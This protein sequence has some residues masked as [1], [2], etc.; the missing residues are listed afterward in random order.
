MTPPRIRVEPEDFV[1]EE[2]PVY[3]PSGSGPH[4]WCRVEKR[5]RTTDDVVDRLA[6]AAGV[7]RRTVGIA[8]R[9]DR[10]AVTRQ[11]LSVPDLD[12]EKAL[13]I[14]DEGVRVLVAT[15]HR[16]RLHLGDLLGNRFTIRVRDVDDAVAGVAERAWAEISRRG[17]PNRFGSQRFGRDGAN[18]DR[19]LRLLAGEPVDAPSWLGR[20]FVSALQARAFNEILRRR[21][22]ACDETMA[23]DVVVEHASGALR[24]VLVPADWDERLAA[25]EVSATIPLFGPKARRTTGDAGRL[26]R[27]VFRELGIPEPLPDRVLRRLRITGERRAVRAPVSD[28]RLARPEGELEVGFVLPPGSFAS[29]LLE[30]LLPGGFI[31]VGREADRDDDREDDDV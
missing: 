20:L 21:P 4:T 3:E 31:E 22:V 29:V 25:F 9:K 8:G 24:P 11:W 13:A 10:R 7:S 17:L 26:E 2:L 30:E 18:P 5:L 28:G 27:E 19:G 14:E 15:R 23:G 1:V 12:P 6:E 16:H